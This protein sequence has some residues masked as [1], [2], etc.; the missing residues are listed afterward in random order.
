MVDSAPRYRKPIHPTEFGY[1]Y[2]WKRNR[3][4]KSITRRPVKYYLMDFGL[5]AKYVVPLEIPNYGG[6]RTLPDFEPPC[7]LVNPFA[8]EIYRLGNLVRRFM[9]TNQLFDDLVKDIAEEDIEVNPS[10]GF[11]SDLVADMTQDDPTKR[12][13]IDEVVER[14][15]GLVKGMS[16]SQ[17]RGEFWPGHSESSWLVRKLWKTPRHKV[18]QLINVLGRHL[19][20]PPDPG[21]PKGRKRP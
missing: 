1:T 2:D 17:L 3:S 5:T 4:P 13:S 14:F 11:I 18:S 15:D 12:P 10:L 16:S 20:I 7:I 21:L 19:P 8:V 9:M 6:D